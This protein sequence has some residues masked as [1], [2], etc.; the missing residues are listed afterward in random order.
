MYVMISMSLKK[1]MQCIIFKLKSALSIQIYLN[2]FVKGFLVRVIFRNL[3]F[4]LGRVVI[5]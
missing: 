1:I 4:V 2:A 3:V 5:D